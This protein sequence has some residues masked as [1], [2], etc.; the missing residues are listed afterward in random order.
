MREASF[1]LPGGLWPDDRPNGGQLAFSD[2]GGLRGLVPGDG[3]RALRQGDSW[4][5]GG[6]PA[7]RGGEPLAGALSR[8]GWHSP[9]RR[10]PDGES[11]RPLGGRAAACGPAFDALVPAGGY[12]WWYIDA[13]SD[14]GKHGLTII[15]F[16][17]SVF[18]PYYHW[19]GR[20]DPDNHVAMNVALYGPR[21]GWCMTERGRNSLSRDHDTL[22]IGPSSMHW[23]GTSLCIDLAEITAPLPKKVRGTI[24]VHPKVMP[25]TLWPLDAQG[26]HA[27]RPIAPRAT[28]EVKLDNP[29]L[30]WRGEGYIDSNAGI[31]P[32]ERG[33]SDWHWSRAHLAR[34]SVVLYE[35]QRRDASRFAMGLR[36]A[37]NGT[38]SEVPLPPERLLPKTLW[39]MP[40]ITRAD[41]G[42]PVEIRRTWEDTPFY[43]RT[44][45]KTRL[46]GEDAEAV[47]ESLSLD[48]LEKGI[49]KLMLPFRMPRRG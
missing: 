20:G 49:V 44:A 8:R 14:D 27:W 46:F 32:L 36:F 24:R 41:A 37:D 19:S 5:E 17:G 1:Q 7:A 42:A 31:E 18:S 33:F 9:R 38:I 35:G 6:F 21:G 4:V 29:S 40:R 13:L 47:H 23:D 16:I 10:D 30:S 34:D 28:V 25:Q 22:M 15:A 3:R 43:S 12:A 45:L 39:R 11:L 2:S 26:H 48:R